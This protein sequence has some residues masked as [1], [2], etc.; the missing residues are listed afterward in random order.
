[1]STFNEK[2]W[3]DLQPGHYDISFHKGKLD[4]SIKFVWHYLFL[5]AAKIFN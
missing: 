5:K 2:F 3:N 4:N 1:M